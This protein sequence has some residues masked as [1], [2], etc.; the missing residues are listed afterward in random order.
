MRLRA[1]IA[2]LC[3]ALAALAGWPAFV[4]LRSAS[5]DTAVA[6]AQFTPAP[7]TPDYLQRDHSVEFYERA[8]SRSPGDQI[9]AH[10]LA[11]QYLMRFR[12]RGDVGDLR[13]ARVAAKRSLA[14]Q[15]RENS[16]AEG[17]LASVAL[18]LH[19]FRDARR[20]GGDV[21][22]IQ[23]WSSGAVAALASTDMELGDYSAAAS[24]LS[25]QPSPYID[26][27]WESSIARY[28]ELTGHLQA[29]RTHVARGMNQVD[30]VFDNPAEARAWYHFRA[31]ELAFEAGDSSAAER[32]LRSAL[33]IFPNDAKAYNALARIY[34]AEHRWRDALNAAG[35]GADLIPLPETLG[36]KADAQ[37]ALG[38]S[39][40]ARETDDLIGAVERIGNA[41]G[42]N[43]RAIA[44]YESEH[45]ERL[46]DAVRIARR[47][48]AARDDIFAEDTLA[49]ALAMDG[50][51]AEARPHAKRAVALGI[52]DS[53]I[54][55]HAGMIALRTGYTPEARDRLRRALAV[56]PHF[57]AVYAD[58]AR[59][60]L[61][62]LH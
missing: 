45:G 47:D 22:R 49:W 40:G 7:V 33:A 14:I 10:M 51:W 3:L 39:E 48:L 29:A 38:D 15:P 18:A 27:T 31:G 42:I 53:R 57:H 32:D 44:V 37:R 59:R 62:L 12:E 56:N 8:V 26:A 28:D 24:L 58:D 16:G 23:P 46:A 17:A 41:N 34:C 43:D 20:Y 60:Q 35:R 1:T 52:E 55:Y 11:S 30:S 2:V 25:K 19:Q 5:M 6:A 50:R 54:Q 36:Y 9:M 4:A 61:G 21:V 13:R